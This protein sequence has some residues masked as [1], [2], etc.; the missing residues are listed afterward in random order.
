MFFPKPND[1]SA[2]VEAM[3]GMLRKATGQT[4]H[5]KRM[6]PIDPPR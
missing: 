5:P 3:K 4:R 1:E 6:A 2:I